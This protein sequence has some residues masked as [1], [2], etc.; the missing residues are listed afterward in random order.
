MNDR[1]SVVSHLRATVQLRKTYEGLCPTPGEITE[2]EK[3]M[4]RVSGRG[5]HINKEDV[6][7]E[8][9]TGD[10]VSPGLFT[11]N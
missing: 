7:N 2:Q 5:C 10:I 9:M 3:K 1:G 8:L 6:K 4:K 11:F